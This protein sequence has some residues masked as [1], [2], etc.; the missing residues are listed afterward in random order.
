ME[1]ENWRKLAKSSQLKL[2]EK[3]HRQ[4]L[5]GVRAAFLQLQLQLQLA[6]SKWTPKSQNWP[7]S[8]RKSPLPV[9][10]TRELAEG[11]LPLPRWPLRRPASQQVGKLEMH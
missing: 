5:V 9:S 8:R 6:A 10:G 4:S 7:K 1:T 2:S 11:A 3:A